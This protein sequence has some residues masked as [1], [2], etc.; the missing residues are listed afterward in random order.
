MDSSFPLCSTN[1]GADLAKF[2]YSFYKGALGDLIPLS[3]SSLR[4][5]NGVGYAGM[6]DEHPGMDDE[7]PAYVLVREHSHMVAG[8]IARAVAQDLDRNREELLSGDDSGLCSAWEELCVQ[9]QGEESFFFDAYRDMALN[10]LRNRAEALPVTEQRM[11]WWRTDLGWDWLWD[12]SNRS[13]GEPSPP[14]PGIDLDEIATWLFS[15]ALRPLAENFSNAHIQQFLD[16]EI[17]DEDE[18]ED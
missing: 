17:E 2:R 4:P 6:D 9:V 15:D 13:P 11:L 12:A 18:D 14:D 10:L 5:A 7:H 1:G 8:Q 16:D 3:L